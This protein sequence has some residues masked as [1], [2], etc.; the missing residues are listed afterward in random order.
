MAVNAQ[1]IVSLRNQADPEV[2]KLASSVRDLI[3]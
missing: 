3:Q 1:I 2:R